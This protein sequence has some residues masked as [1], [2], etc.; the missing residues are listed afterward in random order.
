VLLA[1][2]TQAS[3][4]LLELLVRVLQLEAL[5]LVVSPKSCR[6]GRE[7]VVRLAMVALP[8]LLADL[9]AAL[10]HERELLHLD[11]KALARLLERRTLA[12]VAIVVS[13]RPR[14]RVFL[15]GGVGLVWQKLGA[16]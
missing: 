14:L 3:K 10:P 2:Y 5:V 16:S 9:P 13:P 7:R 4:A 1:P 6:Q 15:G 11:G 8:L 12:S